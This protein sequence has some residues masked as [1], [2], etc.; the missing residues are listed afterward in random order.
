MPKPVCPDCI[1]EGV[2]RYRKPVGARNRCHTHTQ[3][4]KQRQRAS[5]RAKRLEATYG[6]TQEQYDSLYAYQ[7]GKCY[8][9]QRA[10]GKTK[11]LSVDHDH[12]TGY[13]RGL[14]CS[15]CNKQILGHVR[16]DPAALQ[17]AID[18]LQSP[19][20]QQHLGLIK[21]PK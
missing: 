15:P 6:I 7:G 4:Q 20:A 3:Q 2:T 21:A 13:V 19:P 14:L 1:K 5:R 8:I 11:A 17:R 12:K 18:Y 9:C 10:T 16:D